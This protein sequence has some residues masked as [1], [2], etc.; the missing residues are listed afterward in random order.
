MEL[1]HLRYFVTVAETLNFSQAARRLHIAQPPLSAQV[2]SLEAELGVQLFERTSRGVSLTKAGRA[3]LPAARDT[4]NAAQRASEAARVLASGKSGLLRLGLISPAA[5]PEL[6]A[7]LKK[8]HRA[9]PLVQL[10]V[11]QD[12]AATLQRLLESDQLDVAITRPLNASPRFRQLKLGDQEQG[13]ALPSDHPWARRRSIPT[14]LLHRAPLLLINPES[15]PNYGQLLLGRC[16]Q[17]NVQPAINYAAADLATLVWLV[18]AGLGVCPYPL[19]LASTVP[20][21]V[22]VRPFA[23][24]LR[25]LELVALWPAQHASPAIEA[26]AAALHP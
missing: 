5:T 3:L 15:N 9:H 24:R 16:A 12:D 14:R 7:R 26:F 21:G 17:L 22:A 25:Q 13:L 1:R 2:R 4:L 10:R 8:F 6:A 11:R 19:S 23:P 18:S 20:R